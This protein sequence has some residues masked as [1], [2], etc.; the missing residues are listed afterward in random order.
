M[1]SST[2]ANRRT[3]GRSALGWLALGA[4]LLAPRL[5]AAQARELTRAHT[6]E[7]VAHAPKAR[8]NAAQAGVAKAAA[9]A[10]G[11]TALDNPVLSASG[12]LRFNEDGSR[13]FAGT[14]TLSWPVEVGG[15]QS[16]RKDAA[17]AELREAQVTLDLETRRL[18]TQAL[19]QHALVLRDEQE[20]RIAQARKENAER[21]MTSALKRRQAGSVPELDVSLATLQLGRDSASASTAEG[22]RDADLSKLEAL[23]GLPLGEPAQVS[24]PLVPEGAPPPLEALLKQLDQSAAVRAAA[25][26]LRAAQARVAREKA[27][28]APT[29][30]LLAQYERDDGANVGTIGIA[31]PLPI[32]NANAMGKATSSAEAR[33][34]Q[35]EY[36]ATRA[37]TQGEL[38][39]LYVR[40][41]ATKKARE[42]LEPTA[43][44]VKQA[45]ALATR[46]YELGEGDLASV[47]LVHREALEAERALLDIE[48]QHAEAKILL[49]LASGRIPK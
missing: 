20:L 1:T 5:A 48:H 43:V 32:L 37:A 45:V 14:A 22:H 10:A 28:G 31:L 12:G 19:L 34:A 4:A 9:G 7:L 35:A 30:S 46:S 44:A 17:N 49:F 21:V 16:T 23:L 42:S 26:R 13:P 18:L 39:E 40:Y 25:A 24:G 8:A 41:E 29:L 2:I 36:D 11:V 3:A 15:K 27:A 33:A 6:V 47:L 38:R